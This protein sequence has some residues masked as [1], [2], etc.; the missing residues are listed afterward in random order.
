MEEAHSRSKHAARL[1]VGPSLAEDCCSCPV[2]CV[3]CLLARGVLLH[4]AAGVKHIQVLGAVRV[5]QRPLQEAGEDALPSD[6]LVL[7][8][9]CGAARFA[10]IHL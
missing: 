9:V 6:L 5:H 1:R 8:S 10:R 4:R 7:D 2:P 3:A